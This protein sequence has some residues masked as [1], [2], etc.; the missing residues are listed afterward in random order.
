MGPFVI[1][2]GGKGTF[3][4]FSSAQEWRRI[5]GFEN[6]G[7]FPFPRKASVEVIETDGRER[8]DTFEATEV[9]AE[10]EV[11]GVDGGRQR[12]SE[13]AVK[14]A[15]PTNDCGLGSSSVSQHS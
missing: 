10:L 14:G 11:G 4:R 15:I 13:W 12:D 7:P 5:P 3:F 1:G 8:R 2:I 9:S 6:L